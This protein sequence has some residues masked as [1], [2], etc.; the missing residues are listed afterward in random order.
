MNT[1]WIMTFAVYGIIML[2]IGYWGLKKGGES[3]AQFLVAGR[4]VGPMLAVAT[5]IAT[6]QSGVAVVGLSGYASMFGYSFIGYL[7]IPVG[8]IGILFVVVAPRIQKSGFTTIPELIEA[9]YQSYA[10]RLISTFI[11]IILSGVA[12][13]IQLYAAGLV[14]HTVTG[15]SLIGSIIAM[16]IILTIYTTMG[17]LVS[18]I[19]TDFIQA[20]SMFVGITIVVF[21]LIAKVGPDIFIPISP[22]YELTAGV[23]KS[24][25]SVLGWVFVWAPGV[26]AQAFY[27]QRFYACKDVKTARIM[28]GYG[29]LLTTIFY[30]F[31][32]IIGLGASRLL[33]PE[34]LGDKAYPTLLT[35]VL[36][37]P[38]GVLGIILLIAAVQSSVDSLLHI[39]GSYASEDIYAKLSGETNE[40]K[41]SNVRRG[42]TFGLGLVVISLAVVMALRPLPLIV[43]L[44]ALSQGTMGAALCLPIFAGLFWKRATKEGA[45]FGMVGGLI[46]TV[47]AFILKS[48]GLITIFHESQPGLI[49]SALL[50]VIVSL[51][52]K[53]T[54]QTIDS[55]G[56]AK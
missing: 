31:I 52:T 5:W 24:W 20:I 18:V 50:F 34:L 42:I 33:A 27:L 54:V 2:L 47:I 44:Q 12:V 26:L 43:Q 53:P 16:G 19:R 38:I 22:S 32:V 23:V 28:V 45:L 10:L 35:T 36:G 29:T 46:V 8:I 41:V 13:V 11:V 17:G 7:A 3:K 49:A 14:I 55:Q 9:R 39:M 51:A 25:W 15:M 40:T 1:V 37:G 48:Q 30:S 6:F 56:I 4:S 21:A